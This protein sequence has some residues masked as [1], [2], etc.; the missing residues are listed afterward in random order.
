MSAKA[1]RR[2]ANAFLETAIE[3]K[4]I[5]SAHDDMLL[6]QNTLQASND[7]RL[8]LKSPIVKKE[9]KRSVLASI[10]ESKI[11][12]LTVNLLTLLSDKSRVD[13]L[14][15]I[16]KHFIELY[17][18]YHGIIEVNVSSASELEK[19]QLN[20]LIKKLES[21]T[22]KKVITQ[23]SV[24]KDLIGGILVRIDDTV[25]D[26]T[27]KYKLNQLKDRFASAVVE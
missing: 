7:L 2:Y 27:V 16:A 21:V 1:A 11:S 13:L 26:G 5:E 15:D 23:T 10:F 6:M 3:K 24:N 18:R 25:I 14:E 12:G 20:T 22:G 17:N 19:S 4:N 9:Q 8:A